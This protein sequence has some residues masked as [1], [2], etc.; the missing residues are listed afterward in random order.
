LDVE[1]APHWKGTTAALH[2]AVRDDGMLRRRGLEGWFEETYDANGSLVRRVR[3]TDTNAL[4]TR[5]KALAP[6]RYRD[7]ARV[8][9]TGRHGGPVEVEDRSASLA[10]VAAVLRAA[11][12]L[13]EVI[14]GVA[15]EDTPPELEAP[16]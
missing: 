3:R 15:V 9:V 2:I 7:N 8:E 11:G 1:G 14:D 10:D 6:E 4:V 12:A 13:D 16:R 5:L